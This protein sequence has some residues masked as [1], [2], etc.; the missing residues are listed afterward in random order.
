MEASTASAQAAIP[1]VPSPSPALSA[2][3]LRRGGAL[4]G[5]SHFLGMGLGFLSSVLM[6][7][8]AQRSDVASYLLLLQ[9]AVAVAL[10]FELGLGQAALRFAPVCRGEGGGSTTRLLRRRLLGLEVGVWL[11]VGPLLY[12]AWPAIVRRLDAP[13]LAGAAPYLLATAMLA[14]LGRLIDA[15]LRAFRFY[16][17]SAVLTHLVPRGLLCGGFLVLYLTHLRGASWALLMGLFLTAQLLT[18]IV[19]AA[20]LPATTAAELS[21]PRIAVPP[22]AI[23]EIFH[24]T[25]AMGLRNAASILMISSDL[26]ILSWARSHDEV[27][28]YGVVTRIVQVMGALP[29]VANFLIPQEFA[30]LYADG[31]KTELER[32]ARTAAT[33]VG[34]LSLC[35]LLGILVFGRPLLRL[36]FGE[37]YVSGWALLLILAVGSF[38]D[39]ASGSAG[40]VLQMTGNHVPLLLLTL[41][42][43]TFNALLNLA[44]ARLWGGYGVA[45]A[46][47]LT[48]IALNV[49][50]V[51]TARRRVGVRTFVYLRL[52]EWRGVLGL[53]VPRLG[54]ENAG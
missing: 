46:T 44:F 6:V 50:M 28:V 3:N 45:M 7:R 38:W 33:A 10:V 25:F 35:A 2:Q 37:S 23:R 49:A 41:G 32:L 54:R 51:A 5:A 1:P 12:L 17:A 16:T 24:T 8:V 22:P 9:A 14:A 18:A 4:Y 36:A 26:W 53:L 21:E 40:Y 52:A 13:E 48:L 31:R 47:A 43:A 27:A 34:I 30:L 15:Y 20:C 11:L 19:Y 29:L 42:G 39:A